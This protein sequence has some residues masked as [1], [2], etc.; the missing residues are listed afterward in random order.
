MGETGQYHLRSIGPADFRSTGFARSFV[1]LLLLPTS[2]E[3]CRCWGRG[4]RLGVR[5]GWLG[6]SARECWGQ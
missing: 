1:Q 3:G 6:R 2:T 5:W 4:W